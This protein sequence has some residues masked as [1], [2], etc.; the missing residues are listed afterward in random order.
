MS[1]TIRVGGRAWGRTWHVGERF[2]FPDSPVVEFIADGDELEVIKEAMERFDGRRGV[3]AAGGGQLTTERA[4]D[5]ILELRRIMILTVDFERLS[6]VIA[7]AGHLLT[8][9]PEPLVPSVNAIIFEAE[10][11]L[12]YARF[13]R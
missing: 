3:V 9:V 12:R 10:M 6:R 4:I 5:E 1:L 2:E 7:S 13:P 11:R 8:R